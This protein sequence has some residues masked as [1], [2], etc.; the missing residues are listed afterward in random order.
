M[1]LGTICHAYCM[2]VDRML[3]TRRLSK[4]LQDSNYN[5]G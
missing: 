5:N 4:V 2:Y 1:L 3:R